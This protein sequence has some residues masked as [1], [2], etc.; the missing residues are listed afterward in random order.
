MITM[1]LENKRCDG[2]VEVL[3]SVSLNTRCRPSNACLTVC[4]V[5]L[6]PCT[7]TSVWHVIALV[8]VCCMLEVCS[9]KQVIYSYKHAVCMIRIWARCRL[10]SVLL[11]KVY[12]WL[13]VCICVSSEAMEALHR[14]LF[15]SEGR[16]ASGVIVIPLFSKLFSRAYVKLKSGIV[17]SC[18]FWY[19]PQAA[20]LTHLSLK[21]A[22]LF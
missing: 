22:S 3:H 6:K 4:K 2:W 9:K 8:W 16:K 15:T 12:K 19:P 10:F 7:L 14:W 5:L 13:M 18:V 1:I 21:W 17:C 11:C 20:R